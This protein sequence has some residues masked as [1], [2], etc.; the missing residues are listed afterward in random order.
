[1]VWAMVEDALNVFMCE[2][3]SE[4]EIPNFLDIL[5]DSPTTSNPKKHFESLFGLADLE[6]ESKN[7]TPSLRYAKPTAKFPINKD[8]VRDLA[9]SLSQKDLEIE[10]MVVQAKQN[11][12]QLESQNIVGDFERDL[13]KLEC[14]PLI[15]DLLWK[16]KE[17]FGPL[18]PW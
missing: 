4:V 1:M 15:K 2:L 9:L 10:K 8:Q 18:P 13:A 12:F 16:Y 14:P 11:P 7:S 5:E 17:V 6:R 3:L